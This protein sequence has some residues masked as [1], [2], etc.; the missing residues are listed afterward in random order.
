M[1]FF[2]MEYYLLIWNRSFEIT[3][4]PE[5]LSGAFVRG[6]MASHGSA[7]AAGVGAA[8]ETGRAEVLF[9]TDAVASAR[10]HQP[11]SS[12]YLALHRA[13]F[14]VPRILV[15]GLRYDPRRKWGMGPVPHSGRIHLTMR[16]QTNR[17]F[18]LLAEQDGAS[19]V[20]E[21]GEL[22]YPVTSLI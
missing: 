22:G 11:G 2:A 7:F 15:L 3:I 1:K 17:E 16:D 19:L 10:E 9:H 18:I 8:R 4:T 21:A 13:N 5:S 12:S 6:G 14:S 20:K